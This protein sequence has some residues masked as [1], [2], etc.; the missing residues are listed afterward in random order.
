VDVC[1]VNFF[2][3][4]FQTSFD[5]DMQISCWGFHPLVFFFFFFF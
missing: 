4:D 2:V 5:R 1:L 3:Y